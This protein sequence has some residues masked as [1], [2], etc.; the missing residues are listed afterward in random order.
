M[1]TKTRRGTEPTE[2]LAEGVQHAEGGDSAQGIRV[3]IAQI[4][5]ATLGLVLIGDSPLITHRFS[6]KARKWMLDK[7]MKQPK[8][9]REAKDPHA[10]FLES[11]Y[12][13]PGK[14]DTYGFPSIGFKSSAVDAAKMVNLFKTDTR[15]SFHINGDLVTI[16]CP[17]GPKMRE[18]TVRIGNGVTDLRYRAEFFPWSAEILLRY[19]KRALSADQIVNLFN[20]AGF[21]I[22][23]GEWRPAK[24]GSFGMY[25]VKGAK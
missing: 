25:H 13:V 11:M 14:K 17:T 18:D 15:G 10:D 1:A 9:A 24:D 22:G 20:T 23:V 12:P 16:L 8:Q 7:Q 3:N 6:D 21:A 2:Q 19:N 5:L 4:E